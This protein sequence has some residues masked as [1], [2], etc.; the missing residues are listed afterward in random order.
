MR[1]PYYAVLGLLLLTALTGCVS[2]KSN[3]DPQ[4]NEQ[5]ES[6]Y[7]VSRSHSSID[8]FIIALTQ[9][10]ASQ[11]ALQGVRVEY[12]ISD[13]MSLELEQNVEAKVKEFGGDA[14]LLIVPTERSTM[15]GLN[16]S[17]TMDFALIPVGGERIAWRAEVSSEGSGFGDLGNTNGIAEKA[18]GKMLEDGIRLGTAQ[19]SSAP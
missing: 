17:V 15:D 13:P 7:L 9:A 14:M 6:I 16:K 5:V 1:S 8:G 2:V 3:V 12:H 10:M 11:L 19:A 18:V 4:F